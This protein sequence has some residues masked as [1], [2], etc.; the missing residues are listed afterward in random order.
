MGHHHFGS[1]HGIAR[2][3]LR[4]HARHTLHRAFVYTL[5]ASLLLSIMPTT[6][7]AQ[8]GGNAVFLPNISGGLA[9]PNS[10]QPPD[11]PTPAPT[12]A[13]PTPP[14]PTPTP[15]P[16]ETDPVEQELAKEFALPGE[17]T[18]FT[19][20]DEVPANEI[21]AVLMAQAVADLPEPANAAGSNAADNDVDA[22][23]V[24]NHADNCPYQPNPPRNGEQ[25]R[26]CHEALV[27]KLDRLVFLHSRIFLPPDGLDSSL[28]HTQSRSRI[29][30][31][32]HV[33]P[34][35]NGV[36]LHPQQRANLENLGVKFLGYLPHN[37]YF[38]SLPRDLT[39]VQQIVTLEHVRGISALRPKDRVAPDVR[40]QGAENGRNS[41]GT[42]SFDVEFFADVPQA[43]IEAQLTQAGLP[44][45]HQ[46]EHT[47]R[48]N[49]TKWD[50]LRRLAI[51]DWVRFIEDTPD[52]VFNRTQDGQAL[53]NGQHV[54]N[55]MGFRG[56]GIIV[57]MTETH[58]A[59]PITRTDMLGRVTLGNNPIFEGDQDEDNDHPQMVSGIMIS[60][61]G[62]F[63]DRAGLL[64]EAELISYSTAGL[65]LRAQHFGVN[66]EAHDDFGAILSN[67][68]WGPSNCNKIGK[69]SKRGK[70]FDRAVYDV[71]I[72][73]VYA[74]G[75]TRGP[76]G[77]FAEE[78]CEADLYSLPH[79][80]AKNDISVGNWNINTNALASSSS[81]G[82][83]ED[84]RLK[85]D[86]VAPGQN[87]DTVGWDDTLETP[88][89]IEGGGTSAA[90]P[91]TSGVVGWLAES[92]LDQGIILDSIMPARYKAILTHTAKDVGPT[93]P[94]FMHGYGLIQADRAVRI[95]EQW[96]SW[97]REG[98]VDENTTQVVY[99]FD[100]TTPMAFYKATLA[101]DDEEGEHNSTVS[102]K[103]DL[104]LT[105]ISPSG[106]IHRPYEII[107]PAGAV[108]DNGSVPCLVLAC[109]DRLNNVE[110]VMA[111]PAAGDWIEQGTWEAV[112]DTHRLVSDEQTFSLVLTPPCPVVLDNDV[113]LTGDIRCEGH[114]LEPTAVLMQTD[115]V[116]LNCDG[117][118]IDGVSA[119]LFGREG[120]YA[121]IRVMADD[122]TVRNCEIRR[123]DVGIK[124]GD[125]NN[126]PDNALLRNN[127]LFNNGTIGIELIGDNHTARENGISQM[128]WSDGK[129]IMVRGD[130][131][132]LDQNG[133]YTARTG[134]DQNT[135]V[136]ILVQPGA[137]SGTITG[138]GF[139][140]FWWKGI[141]LRGGNVD[142]P[143]NNFLID[144][145]EFEG[146][147]LIPIEL[148]GEAQGNT[149]SANIIQAYGNQ[150]PAINVVAGDGVIPRNNTIS[151]NFI[152]G[153]D[154]ER[155]HGIFVTGADNT[156]VTG[157]DLYF[158]GQGIVETDAMDTL[159]S[160]NE[161]NPDLEPG[162]Y[163]TTVGI[164]STNSYTTTQIISNII[165]LSGLG[166]V[167][168]R[169][170]DEAIVRD[171]IMN[172][173]LIGISLNEAEAASVTRNGVTSFISGIAV[174]NSHQAALTDNGLNMRGLGI[175]IAV[176]FS[177]DMTINANTII[178]PSVGIRITG[179]ASI[180]IQGNTINDPTNTG[181]IIKEDTEG[182]VED[183]VINNSTLGIH[184]RSGIDAKLLENEVN[185]LAGGVGIRLGTGEAA[186]PVNVDNILVQDNVLNGGA[187]GVEVLCDVGTHTLIN[188]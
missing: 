118:Q 53:I 64:P 179:T 62:P 111:L 33:W 113:T 4:R 18:P 29:H 86:L 91:V 31:M 8:E 21:E 176:G 94:D 145:N 78:G 183:N 39:T 154:N 6:A 184:Y 76:D 36:V 162:D 167:V 45:E 1:K 131:V 126:S 188:N 80:V 140:G 71:G 87:I 155:Q 134:G 24:P 163:L 105:L 157:N 85:P 11:Q 164:Q 13:P 150:Q 174:A 142:K 96:S 171:N 51:Q 108:V 170:N 10:E 149:V 129:G 117:H 136:G 144:A 26:I 54:S 114:L 132:E 93:G 178:S 16:G 95:A 70:F 119:T 146:I 23:G 48:V 166:I 69:Y 88:N 75:N 22:D 52:P 40:V 180:A 181:I 156:D 50:D 77:L 110:Q 38:V 139:S 141:R 68:S 14:P 123:F 99:T 147:E 82:P 72:V 153:F 143:I 84:E 122:V 79:P 81:A 27:K 121:G 73:I 20:F 30:V 46:Y 173:A 63:P 160:G 59:E 7:F 43:D 101:W 109:Q 130:F 34:N 97:G 15:S 35:D 148:F 25:P 127:T 47:Y 177:D 135:T 161:I 41:D 5:I 125:I 67:N 55:T 12:D 57:S 9:E 17:G 32:L 172:V 103:N 83:A 2:V 137:D 120:I 186:C 107:L 158:V 28:K 102:L 42:M 3:T 152:I 187:L 98:V 185:S 175:G 56:Q 66:E 169:P 104:D 89:A 182:V 115:N 151:G 44:F 92:F 165:D 124:V 65:T 116:N 100:V 61:G 58:L 49:L 138:N 128:V 159:I 133:F 106:V 112:V 90:S 19:S 37:A 74:A 60:D 168:N